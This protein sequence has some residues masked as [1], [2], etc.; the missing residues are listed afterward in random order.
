MKRC[1][2]S[3]K[4]PWN[5]VKALRSTNRSSKRPICD[6]DFAL[7]LVCV[8]MLLTRGVVML[9]KIGKERRV[10]GISLVAFSDKQ[11]SSYGF[12]EDNFLLLLRGI[13]SCVHVVCRRRP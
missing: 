5:N 7:F 4:H 3:D 6:P 8:M 10:I 2:I 11:E 13:V 1:L 9:C 12:G